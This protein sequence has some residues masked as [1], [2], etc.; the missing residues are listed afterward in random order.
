MILLADDD[1]LVLGMLSLGLTRAGYCVEAVDSGDDAL[2]VCQD[3]TPNLVILDHNMTGMSGL[4]VAQR[5]RQSANIPVLMLTAH[6]DALLV[7]RAIEVGVN[8]YFVKPMD[9]RQLIPSI[10]LQLRR[11]RAAAAGALVAARSSDGGTGASSQRSVLVEPGFAEAQGALPAGRVEIELRPILDIRRRAVL[12]YEALPRLRDPDGGPIPLARFLCQAPHSAIHWLDYRVL[13]GVVAHLAQSEATARRIAM[14]VDAAHFGTPAL[15]G[16]VRAVLQEYAVDPHRLIF[17]ASE[18]AVLCDLD[19]AS[20]FVAQMKELG[21]E[22]A[23]S[24]FGSCYS[25]FIYLKRL[26]ADYV[27]IDGAFVRGLT[28]NNDNRLLVQAMVDVARAFSIRTIA[29]GVG[30]RSTLDLLKRLGVD[31]AQGFYIGGPELLGAEVGASV[32]ADAVRATGA[33]P[34]EGDA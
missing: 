5:I 24:S 19:R 28:S 12:A 25:S 31:L 3:R 11:G 33:S 26:A 20:R 8:G 17:E 16:R 18:R 27:R 32:R 29:D 30:D 34:E 22:F 10:E 13:E 9:A 23:L 4:E 1:R 14:N 7:Q 15:R 21:C 2:A 6:D